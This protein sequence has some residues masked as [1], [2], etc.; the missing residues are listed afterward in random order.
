MITPRLFILEKVMSRAIKL[1]GKILCAERG[2]ERERRGS[3]VIK[4]D[5]RNKEERANRYI[6]QAGVKN[7]NAS[8]SVKRISYKWNGNRDE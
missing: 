2:R 4:W 7:D 8:S 3:C 6:L 1:K 5:T